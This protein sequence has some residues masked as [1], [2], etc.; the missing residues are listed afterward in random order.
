MFCTAHTPPA[1]ATTGVP[2]HHD[3]R[4]RAQGN[5]ARKPGQ[6]FTDW[7]SI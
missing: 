3:R 5:P 7:A 1:L 6:V 2:H 4:V